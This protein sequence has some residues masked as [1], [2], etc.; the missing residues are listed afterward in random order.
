MPKKVVV[1]YGSHRT[2]GNSTYIVDTLL[3][4]IPEGTAE[5]QKF[6]LKD[7]NIHNCTGCSRCR[8]EDSK[9]MHDDDMTTL[10]ESIMSADKI[11]LAT[12][13]FMFQAASTFS[14]FQQR[15][16]PL[17]TGTNGQYT[18][19]MEPKDTVMVYSQGAPV[20]FAFQTYIDLNQN[21]LTM[22]GFNVVETIVCTGANPI[23]SAEQNTELV[24]RTLETGRKFFA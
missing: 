3:S 1:V 4:T 6:Y 23:G 13:I 21:S 2:N 24:Q 14:Q 10:L 7:L 16:Y 11:V 8:A 18:R 12:P 15:C 22:L 5:V 19:R 17:L 9:C 20:P